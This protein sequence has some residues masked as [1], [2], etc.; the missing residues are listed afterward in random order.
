MK[1]S[2]DEIKW[3]NR[4]LDGINAIFRAAVINPSEEEFGK[5]CLAVCEELTD[6]EFSFMGEINEK[7][8]FDGVAVSAS[9]MVKLQGPESVN[10][11][12][13]RETR[14]KALEE[15]RIL[16]FNNPVNNPSILMDI[17]SLI[18]LWEHH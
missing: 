8:R 17:I 5:I 11:N 12:V 13:I 14:S 6:S 10:D 15:E 18:H 16:I 4:I 2:E 1:K 3:K 7:G 9:N